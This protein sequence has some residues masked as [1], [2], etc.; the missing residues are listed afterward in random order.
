MSRI[1]LGTAQFGTD[2]GISNRGG[3]PTEA[4]VAAILARAVERGIGYL[5]TAASYA[6][7]EKLIGRNLPSGHGLRIITK[8][9]AIAEDVITARHNGAV[10]GAVAASLER[11]AA[12]RVYGVLIHH[13]HDLGKPGWQH[14]VDA[15]REAQGRGWT[16]HIGVSVYDAGDLDLVTS[17]FA[18]EIVQ[19][20]F[21]ALDHRLAVSGWLT[22]LRASGAE[23]HA[24]SVFLQGLLLMPPTA[25][26]DFF[27][28][29]SG[30]LAGLHARW[31]GENL[32]P[33]AGCLRAATSN[34]DIGVA[35]VG[36]NRLHELTEIEAALNHW[37]GSA[38]FSPPPIDPVYLDPRRWPKTLH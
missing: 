33:L 12:A 30:T 25:L 26:P 8:L 7:A 14:L 16:S 10:L 36:V 29:I 27:T 24:R 2:Y 6:D 31:A 37:E 15:L 22:R 34:A 3:R 32:S 38:D 21:N 19:L 17:R 13:A 5:D 1:G 23:V 9:P 35:I 18:P 11:L 20:P 28:P 4:E